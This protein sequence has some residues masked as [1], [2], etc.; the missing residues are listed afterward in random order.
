MNHNKQTEHMTTQD[1]T[2]LNDGMKQ[3]IQDL[4]W[5]LKHYSKSLKQ[6]NQQLIA[7]AGTSLEASK[8]VAEIFENQES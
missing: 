6:V 8:A 3:L 2:P 7:I 5:N 4:G 1:N